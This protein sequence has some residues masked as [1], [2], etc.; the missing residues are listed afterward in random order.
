M[1]DKINR[2]VPSGV[3][4]SNWVLSMFNFYLGKRVL[5]SVPRASEAKTERQRAV[6]ENHRKVLALL[7]RH[8]VEASRLGYIEAALRLAKLEV[9]K[10]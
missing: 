2:G 5:D 3:S 6:V 4:L 10:P 9:R 1:H 8:G 7:K